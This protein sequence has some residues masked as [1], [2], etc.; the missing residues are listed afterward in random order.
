MSGKFAVVLGSMLALGGCTEVEQAPAEEV[1]QQVVRGCAT[2]ELS[3]EEKQSVEQALAGRVRAQARA[4]GSVNINVY[5]HVINNGT[6]TSQGNIS[7]AAIASQIS[8]LNAAYANT[9]FKF[10]LKATDRTTNSSWYTC[11]GGAC[12]K[13]MKA[14]LR[15]GTAADLNIYSNNMG[16][17][18][19]GW[20]TFPSSYA[21]QPSLDGVVILYSSLP[22]GT[23]APYNEGDTA[24]HEVGHWLG[25]YHTF[26]GGCTGSG[27]Y[28]SDTAAESSAA[29]GCP[30]GRD[31]CTTAG[32]DP[33][34]NFM[35]YT[36]DSC[37]NT[38]S[39][40]QNDRMDSLVQQY[41]GL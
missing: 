10:T 34:T 31:T 36:D 23:A 37:M 20:A 39:T 35:D 12:E 19:L 14:A 9:P 3:A 24:T 27:D 16:Q 22:G 5:W 13:K 32:V 8:V 17:G 18:L 2:Q 33:I 21:S 7:D 38:F 26:Q 1:T 40:G 29:F 4:A 6:S 41:R 25:L 15:Q 28:V 30:T 11:S